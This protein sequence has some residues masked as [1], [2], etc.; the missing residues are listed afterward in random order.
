MTDQDTKYRESLYWAVQDTVK[1][2]E[3]TIKL[4]ASIV[5]RQLTT[6]MTL[7][8]E[9]WSYE[10]IRQRFFSLSHQTAYPEVDVKI[11]NLQAAKEWLEKYGGSPQRKKRGLEMIE[12]GIK[13]LKGETNEHWD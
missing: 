13:H 6:E 11:A 10:A 5:F 3:A 9:I 1:E 8:K 2:A 12:Q 4:I 7:Y